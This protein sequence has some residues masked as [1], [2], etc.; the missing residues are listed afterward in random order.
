MINRHGF[1][2]KKHIMDMLFARCFNESHKARQI[3]IN[4][5]ICED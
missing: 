5:V 1:N 3:Q 4:T 2:K